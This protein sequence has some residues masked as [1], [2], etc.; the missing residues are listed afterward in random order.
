MTNICPLVCDKVLPTSITIPAIKESVTFGVIDMS[1]LIHQRMQAGV[2]H[3][4]YSE[5][6]QTAES[7]IKSVRLNIYLFCKKF[8]INMAHIFCVFDC[9]RSK[10]WRHSVIKKYNE[11]LCKLN[12]LVYEESEEFAL[13][14]KDLGVHLYPIYKGHRDAKNAS[15]KTFNKE[16]YVACLRNL[17]QDNQLNSFAYDSLEADDIAYVICQTIPIHHKVVVLTCDYDYCQI[18]RINTEI[19]NVRSKIFE[20]LGNY[21]ALTSRERQLII[22]EKCLYGDKSDNI[23]KSLKTSRVNKEALLKEIEESNFTSTDVNWLDF[24]LNQNLVDMERIPST[25]ISQCVLDVENR[26]NT[27]LSIK[28][29]SHPN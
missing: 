20:T 9:P 8:D 17:R 1:A 12:G 4:R 29:C 26:F 25:L 10:I 6:E 18:D 22:I 15:S 7:V 23:R 11:K 14:A 24:K 2:V 27:V 19:V 28:W 3:A 5:I 16:I 13:K 21:N